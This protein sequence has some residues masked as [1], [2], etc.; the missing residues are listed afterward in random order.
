MLYPSLHLLQER[1]TRISQ[2]KRGIGQSLGGFQAW[3]FNCPVSTSQHQGVVIDMKYC[4]PKKVH[5][6]F[7]VEFILGFH[8][9]SMIVYMVEINLQP[10]RLAWDSNSSIRS[11]FYNVYATR[12][13]TQDHVFACFHAF[14]RAGLSTCSAFFT[15]QFIVFV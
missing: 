3:N 15:Y 7:S 5:F 10:L 9:L 4:Q 1:K 11:P 14:V 8:Y 13:S 6:N 12:Y 2:W